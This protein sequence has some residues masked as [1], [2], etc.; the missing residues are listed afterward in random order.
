[1][2]AAANVLV[3]PRTRSTHADNNIMMAS[4]VNTE[5]TGDNEESIKESSPN[6]DQ[7]SWMI[8]KLLTLLGP[9]EV[10]GH[11]VQR[12]SKGQVMMISILSVNDIS[13]DFWKCIRVQRSRLLRSV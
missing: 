6:N 10:T 1:M 13:H 2:H 12:R 3:I 5:G 8:S 9:Q 7:G 4:A 11:V